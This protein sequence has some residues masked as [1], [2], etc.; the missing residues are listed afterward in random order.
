[1]TQWWRPGSK[2]DGEA[3]AVEAQ[4]REPVA[5][6]PAA[7]LAAPS[8]QLR[9]DAVQRWLAAGPADDDVKRLLR[10]LQERD[11]GA[12]RLLR[13]HLSSRQTHAQQ[14][15]LLQALTAQAVQLAGKPELQSQDAVQLDAQLA[16]TDGALWPDALR[17]ARE[18]IARR[19]RAQAE[20]QAQLRAAL[21]QAA[22]WRDTL[23]AAQAQPLSVALA[24]RDSL[25]AGLERLSA[26]GAALAADAEW[27]TLPAKL[28][29]RWQAAQAEALA[30]W[31][32]FAA[33]LARAE[34][35]RADA[36]AELPHH[37]AWAQEIAQA[38]MPARAVEVE[39]SAAPAAE[40]GA[41]VAE[42]KLTIDFLERALAEGHLK[43]AQRHAD[44]LRAI[45]NIAGHGLPA[46]LVTR[47]QAAVVQTEQLAQWQR[48]RTDQLREELCVKAEALRDHPLAARAQ[49]DALRQ[50]RDEW[51]ALDQTGAAN[52]ALW[53][54]FDA[55]CTAAHLPVEAFVAKEREQFE[56]VHAARRA[57]IDELRAWQAAAMVDEAQ[58]DWRAIGQ[59]L[60]GFAERW[61]HAG[62]LPEKRFAKLQAEWRAAFDAAAQPLKQAQ[63]AARQQREALIARA[64][65]ICASQ[66]P[67]VMEQLRALL[68][69]WQAEAKRFALP[70][71]LEQKLWERF[72]KPQDAWHEARKQALEARRQQRSAQE[73]ALRDALAALDAAQDAPSIHAAWAAMEQQWDAAFPPRER[74]PL[75]VPHELIALR[76]KAED[77]A[78]K[79]LQHLQ[80]ARRGH[81]VDALLE[82]WAARDAAQLPAVDAWAKPVTKAVLQRWAA[83]LQRPAAGEAGTALLRLELASETDSPPSEHAARRALQLSLLASRGRDALM[84]QW[85][86]DVAQA[87][88]A[89]H[90]EAGAA[91]LKRCLL[92]L[93]R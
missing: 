35:A 50:L 82:A 41:H 69:Q 19:L 66:A 6:E 8:A 27:A 17:E 88:A 67:N 22:Q 42:A 24:Q 12:A 29:S 89:A 87:L 77:G 84:T 30:A 5:A 54:R 1:M 74:P 48:W 33:D 63:A 92:K 31:E 45:L 40:A 20:L 52:G 43:A 38:R 80:Q 36:Q 91:R 81:V 9:A 34:A 85:P 3:S 18:T 58:A 23:R 55:A 51:K 13:E 93:L 16:A 15:Q 26:S 53:Q 78:R 70:R 72:R 37:R 62:H 49:A 90:T 73:Q 39:P 11:R 79:R 2:V 83:A 75:R 25:R 64:E 47:V 76:R 68:A 61:R 46:A 21:A 10:E 56:Q 59:A 71:A 57:L 7:I 28:K 65:E 60:D 44:R 4:Q 86:D 14:L 32:P